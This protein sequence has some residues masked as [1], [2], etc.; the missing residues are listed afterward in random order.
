MCVCLHACA[1]VHTHVHNYGGQ[2]RSSDHL[3]WSYRDLWVG[4][5]KFCWN[6]FSIL[7]IFCVILPETYYHN[8]GIHCNQYIVIK[9]ISVSN[10]SL[11]K[12]RFLKHNRFWNKPTSLTMWYLLLFICSSLTVDHTTHTYTWW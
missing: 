4:N 8:L 11:L 3:H 2:R 10:I 5:L 1:H 6:Y 7:I 9:P 12:S